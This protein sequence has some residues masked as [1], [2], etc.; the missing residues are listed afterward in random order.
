MLSLPIR[1]PDGDHPIQ[2]ILDRVTALSHVQRSS[3]AKEVRLLVRNG[4]MH[5]D[6]EAGHSSENWPGFVWLVE[7][8]PGEVMMDNYSKA[9]GQPPKERLTTHK[10]HG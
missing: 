4:L 9:H 8:D 6:S 1:G 2:P 10:T 5:S 7:L 3:I